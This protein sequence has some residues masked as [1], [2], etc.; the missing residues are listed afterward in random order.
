M[1]AEDASIL[2]SDDF[3]CGACGHE[4][5]YELAPYPN[6]KYGCDK[7][8]CGKLKCLD[9]HADC[10]QTI[11]DGC[12]AFLLGDPQNCGA[13][14]FACLPGQTCSEGFCVGACEPRFTACPNSFFCVDLETNPNNCG[15][16]GHECTSVNPVCRMGHCETVCEPGYAD[17]DDR[18]ENGCETFIAADPR[19]CG[20]CSVRCDL[21]AG[22]PCVN[23]VC[24]VG[25]CEEGE[26]E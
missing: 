14:G 23:G 20:E 4:C 24:L 21:A 8:E 15:V 3:H 18:V 7:S 13:C 10:N 6:M 17:C 26:I 5:P 19:N 11:D 1:P 12:E 25:P 2:T 9:Y 16:C 22:Q